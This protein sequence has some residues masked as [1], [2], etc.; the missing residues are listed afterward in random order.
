MPSRIGSIIAIADKKS[1]GMLDALPDGSRAKS[2]VEG[3]NGICRRLVMR[4]T[5][6]LPT[7]KLVAEEGRK[8]NPHFPLERTIFNSYSKVIRIWKKAYHDIMNIDADAPID[9]NEVE[10]IDTSVM[11]PSTGDLVDRLKEIIYEL[12]QRNNVLKQIVDEGVPVPAGGLPEGV[13]ADE[14]MASLKD[15]LQTLANS[16]FELSDLGVRVSRKT[17]PGSRIMG[18]HL[19]DKLRFFIED[20]E[21][22]RKTRRAREN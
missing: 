17:P 5:P 9:G 11:D 18:G 21:R 6:L 13:G 4:K 2:N 10:K 22:I 19:F 14:I 3:I 1:E 15:W 8:S 16:G 20:F 7:A 12:V